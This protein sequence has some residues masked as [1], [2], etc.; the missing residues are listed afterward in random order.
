MTGGCGTNAR[1]SHELQAQAGLYK[2][3]LLVL[4]R[5]RLSKLHMQRELPCRY[6]MS[7][8]SC[9]RTF[10]M[11]GVVLI[12][13]IKGLPLDED[14]DQLETPE[15]RELL[16]EVLGKRNINGKILHILIYN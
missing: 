5:V 4:N 7:P 13:T 2:G 15:L 8:I 14:L 1:L 16:R 6:T 12:P 9:F 3:L 10:L 11:I